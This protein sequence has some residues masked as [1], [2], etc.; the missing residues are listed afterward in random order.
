MV[1]RLSAAETTSTCVSILMSRM[2]LQTIQR[3][4]PAALRRI[5]VPG[6]GNV[7]TASRSDKHGR[8]S[9]CRGKADCVRCQILAS[10][11]R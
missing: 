11:L 4:L 6:L 5:W 9:V 7:S 8:G 10:V 2:D 3:L 1:A